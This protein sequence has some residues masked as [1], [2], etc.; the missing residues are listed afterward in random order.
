MIAIG[1]DLP[2][3]TFKEAGQYGCVFFFKKKIPMS[4]YLCVSDIVLTGH[5]YWVPLGLTS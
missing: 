4:I 2:P 1:L 3:E 5:I